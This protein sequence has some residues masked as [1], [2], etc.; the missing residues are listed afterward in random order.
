VLEHAG[1]VPTSLYGSSTG[2]FVGVTYDDYI[3]VVPPAGVAED[4][5]LLDFDEQEVRARRLIQDNSRKTFLVLDQSKFGRP[6]HVRGGN[7]GEATMVFCDSRPPD[8][9]VKLLAQSG[10]ELIVCKEVTC[11]FS[12]DHF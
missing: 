12:S 11:P 10:S 3:G 6:A 5:T 8:H 1:I 4:G 9:I 2:V 7:I